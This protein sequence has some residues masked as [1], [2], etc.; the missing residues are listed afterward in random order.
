MHY[1]RT[2]REALQALLIAAGTQAGANVYTGRARPILDILL[3]RQESVISI[4]TSDESSARLADGFRYER[5]LTVTVELAMGGSDDLDD[6]LDAF[7][8][9]VEQAINGDPTLGGVL[10]SDLVLDATV[11]EIAAT[12]QQLVGAVR[13]D[14]SATYYTDAGQ[15]MPPAE[16]P[17]PDDFDPDGAE[18]VV[19]GDILPVDSDFLG[20]VQQTDAPSTPMPGGAV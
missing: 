15:Y 3:R 8:L 11:S 14:Y 9:E 20:G 4:Y 12:G 6:M 16:F 13:M 17:V 1:R 5:Q 10:S 19:A 7:A 18:L 2:I